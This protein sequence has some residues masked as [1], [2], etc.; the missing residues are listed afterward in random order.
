[1]PGQVSL[2]HG[3]DN[4]GEAGIP[5]ALA[6]EH[7]L[8]GRERLLL[9]VA[10]LLRRE[11]DASGHDVA[12]ISRSGDEVNSGVKLVTA[13]GEARHN[14]VRELVDLLSAVGGVRLETVVE[15]DRVRR[16]DVPEV[17]GSAERL[18]A[19]SRSRG[20]RC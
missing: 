12:L 17:R 4:L 13:T 3:R 11:L 10:A 20:M 14:R 5:L 7:G 2:S 6:D 9:Q 16:H 18:R 1:M 19:A 8:T 15:A